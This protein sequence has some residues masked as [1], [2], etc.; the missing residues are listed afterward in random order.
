MTKYIII[1][2]LLLLL[3]EQVMHITALYLL[4]TLKFEKL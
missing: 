1:I 2:Y 4:N 3:T